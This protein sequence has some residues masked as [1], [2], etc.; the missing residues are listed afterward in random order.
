VA[1][2]LLL[3]SDRLQKHISGQERVGVLEWRTKARIGVH[4]MHPPYPILYDW[5]TFQTTRKG[6]WEEHRSAILEWLSMIR[7]D[8]RAHLL[9][10]LCDAFHHVLAHEDEE[11]SLAIVSELISQSK[12][13]NG[14]DLTTPSMLVLVAEGVYEMFGEAEEALTLASEMHRHAAASEEPWRHYGAVLRAKYLEFAIH[15]SGDRNPGE[16][17][18]VLWDLEWMARTGHPSIR[19]LLEGLRSIPL[20]GMGVPGLSLLRAAW[21]D[22]MLNEGNPTDENKSSW[23]RELE[24]KIQTLERRGVGRPRRRK[25][26]EPPSEED[27]T[28]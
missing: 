4:Y 9:D 6:E 14:G 23:L 15:A 3:V 28:R 12:D 21:H 18:R 24:E 16:A 8:H 1:G 7:H 2:N 22:Q 20:K 17:A 26:K 11:A 10:A 19:F 25:E 5:P 27:S 13:R